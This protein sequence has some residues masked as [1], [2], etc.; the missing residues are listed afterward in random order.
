MRDKL[1]ITVLL[2]LFNGLVMTAPLTT[3]AE[4]T[5]LV[6]TIRPAVVTVIVYDINQKVTNIGSGFFIDKQSADQLFNQ[7]YY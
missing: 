6:N 7:I 4:L 2:A 5:K 3:G 1:K